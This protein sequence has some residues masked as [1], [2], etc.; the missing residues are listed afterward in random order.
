MKPYVNFNEFNNNEKVQKAYNFLAAMLFNKLDQVYTKNK[1]AN[2]IAEI[3]NELEWYQWEKAIV[4]GFNLKG[5][6]KAL[7]LGH[8]RRW[9]G[10][11]MV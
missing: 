7:F 2:K 5:K 11:P 3:L 1:Q 10:T 6:N 4:A 9:A 8:S